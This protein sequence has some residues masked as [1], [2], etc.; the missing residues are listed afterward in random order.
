M[1]AAL[2]ETISPRDRWGHIL[3]TR[4]R[5]PFCDRDCGRC[6]LCRIPPLTWQEI[7][8]VITVFP[9]FQKETEDDAMVRYTVCSFEINGNRVQ[10]HFPVGHTEEE[11]HVAVF[12]RAAYRGAYTHD[13]L[14]GRFIQYV[15][16][17]VAYLSTHV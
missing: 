5:G 12:H 15:L 4:M 10:I 1:E 6:T 8:E 3:K 11:P 17:D 7:L 13:R 2:N 16:D 14:S 9:T